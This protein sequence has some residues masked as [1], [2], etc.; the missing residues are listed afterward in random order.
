MAA[1]R[2][3][4]EFSAGDSFGERPH[5]TRIAGG[6]Q[7][8]GYHQARCADRF[9]HRP[10]FRTSVGHAL[11]PGQTSRVLFVDPAG[12]GRD[13]FRSLLDGGI[14]IGRLREVHH[15]FDRVRL[16]GGVRHLQSVLSA[17][18]VGRG[19]RV[20]Q[21]QSG[22]RFGVQAL[23]VHRHVA[24][25]RQPDPNRLLIAGGLDQVHVGSG[26]AIQRLAVRAVRHAGARI[27]VARH[28]GC[29]GAG[30][31]RSPNREVR[32]I[33]QVGE[34]G[35]RLRAHVPHAVVHRVGVHQHHRHAF[36]VAVDMIG[37]FDCHELLLHIRAPL[38][39]LS[40]QSAGSGLNA[41]RPPSLRAIPSNGRQNN[42]QIPAQANACR[43]MRPWPLTICATNVSITSLLGSTHSTSSVSSCGLQSPAIGTT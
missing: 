34:I 5:H 21:G 26:Q 10:Q 40:A 29:A 27:G 38:A 39:E 23:D 30:H 31:V 22:H 24:A 41:D 13:E 3:I 12:H 2:N 7:F 9:R 1:V 8:A 33:V 35:E 37:Q 18:A 14:A 25:H 6:V 42:C 43:T 4:D 11:T 16:F 20:A 36:A 19:H 17:H 28:R 15:R 32:H